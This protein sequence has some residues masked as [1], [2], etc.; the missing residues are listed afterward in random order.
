MAETQVTQSLWK[1]VMGDNP[2][3]FKGERHPVEQVSYD[4][5]VEF[6]KRLSDRIQGLCFA[7]PTERQW[8]HACQAGANGEVGRARMEEAAWYNG[9]SGFTTHPVGQKAPNAW[10]LFDMLGNVGEWCVSQDRESD[11]RNRN[12]GDKK[13]VFYPTRLYRGG[14]WGCSAA[15]C[16]VG[17][18]GFSRAGRPHSGIGLRLC[19]TPSFWGKGQ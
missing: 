5:C 15:N 12:R 16:E 17:W 9:N 10:G 7:L 19:A 14:G 8:V 18:R 6:S 1:E 3:H 2:S 11:C 4:D 13:L